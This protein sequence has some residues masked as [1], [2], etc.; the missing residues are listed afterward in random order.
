MVHFLIEITTMT[1]TMKKVDEFIQFMMDHKSDERVSIYK[2]I[3][4]GHRNYYIRFDIDKEVESKGSSIGGWQRYFR[5]NMTI[6]IDNRNQCILL[7]TD[8]SDRNSIIFEEKSLVEK[9]SSIIEKQISDGLMAEF[10]TM[11][12]QTF[13]RCHR[14][15][16]S[17]DWKIKN[18][19]KDEP[20]QP[21]RAGQNKQD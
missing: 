4:Y 15:D 7:Y 13:D 10:K 9:W 17:R 21:R 5:G 2:D 20:I 3:K 1:I 19:L 6:H 8:E 18:I 12:E 14:K 16:I 11:V